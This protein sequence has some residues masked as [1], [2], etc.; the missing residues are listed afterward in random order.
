MLPTVLC[1]FW[2]ITTRLSVP[3]ESA[4]N[5]GWSPCSR[6]DRGTGC[7]PGLEWWFQVWETGDGWLGSPGTDPKR[8]SM[9]P[10]TLGFPGARCR[11]TPATRNRTNG[12]WDY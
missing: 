5:R 7:P 2:P 6:E 8:W 3:L 12:T 11:S 4:P 10:Q 9:S 1:R